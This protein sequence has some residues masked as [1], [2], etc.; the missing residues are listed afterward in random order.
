MKKVFSSCFLIIL[1][2][3]FAFQILIH[4]ISILESVRFSFSIWTNNIF[5]SLFPFLILSDF[6]IHYGF[7][8]LVGELCKPIMNSLFRVKGEG[9][10]VFIM[11][12][13]SGFPS[14]AKYTRQLYLDGILTEKE[15]SKLLM[16]T[17]FS[18]PLF[19]LGTISAFLNDK[20]IGLMILLCHYGT[21]LIIGLLVR[22]YAPCEKKKEE[23]SLQKAI[24]KMHEKRIQSKESFGLFFYETI[25][26]SIQTLLLILGV[27]TVFLI[28]TTILN[29]TI[30]VSS[31]YQSIF[32]GLFEMTQGLK[33]VSLL[34]ISTKKKA[35]LSTFLLSFGGLSVHL[36][37]ISIL[38]DTRIS[39]KPF[40]LARILH[41][42]LS[43][44][45]IFIVL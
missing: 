31:L 36:Q 33:Y 39:Y 30:P 10:F 12:I 7:V 19:I 29:H 15:A 35:V 20:K 6:L 32:N 34:D 26:Q 24:F 44:V 23:F 43:S 37:M 45:L 2:I 27:I 25:T 1:L 18:N 28:L 4:T 5:P 17:H 21:N 14:N 16:F 3:I 41:A 13:I 8:E 38:S 40:F 42:I 9:A 22:N 11:S